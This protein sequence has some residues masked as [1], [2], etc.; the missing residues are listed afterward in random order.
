M[1]HGAGRTMTPKITQQG[2]KAPQR[3]VCEGCPPPSPM[4]N[5]Y[6]LLGSIYEKHL[7]LGGTADMLNVR[8]SIQN[9]LVS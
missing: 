8:D 3:E 9:I 2:I 7:N 5:P 1:G 6:Q 4:C